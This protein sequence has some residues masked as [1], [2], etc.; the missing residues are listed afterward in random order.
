MI[1]MNA[2]M[3]EIG[4]KMS[5]ALGVVLLT[6]GGAVF[7]AKRFFGKSFGV[8]TNSKGK[9]LPSVIEVEASRAIGQGRT[10][11]VVKYGGK[12]VLIGSTANSIQLLTEFDDDFEDEEE[13]EF[14]SS[15]RSR[16][17]ESEETS[18]KSQLGDKLREIARV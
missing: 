18:I 7:V 4:F 3:L 10:L 12:A 6:F 15:L 11:H 13:V 8:K 2:E 9:A 5:V 14:E 1:E 17:E 16:A